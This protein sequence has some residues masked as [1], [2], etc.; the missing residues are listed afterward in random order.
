M[1]DGARARRVVVAAA[2]RHGSTAD[3]AARIEGTIRE[4][5]ASGW[6]VETVD[7]SDL[8]SFEDADAVVLGSAVYLG[9]WM[10]PAVKALHFVKDESL[11]DLWLFSTGPVSDDVREN[12]SVITADEMVAKGHA[13]EHMVF[14]GRLDPSRLAWWERLTLRIVG[15]VAGDRRDWAAVDAWAISIAGQLADAPSTTEHRS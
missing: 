11:L 10:R 13:T 3:I 8:R 2:S 14:A 6:V 1:T 9:R 4:H 5:L 7:V 15:A 12:E